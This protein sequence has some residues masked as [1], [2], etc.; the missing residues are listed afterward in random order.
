MTIA[1]VKAAGQVDALRYPSIPA[2]YAVCSRE[3]ISRG[4]I[5]LLR[6]KIQFIPLE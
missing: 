5:P 4:K 3:V 6:G 1:P 2:Y